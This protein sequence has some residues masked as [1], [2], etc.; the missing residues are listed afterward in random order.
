MSSAACSPLLTLQWEAWIMLTKIA[1]FAERGQELLKEVSRWGAFNI[2]GT[3]SSPRYVWNTE[4]VADHFTSALG[5]RQWIEAQRAIRRAAY[6][7]KPNLR[8]QG[9]NESDDE[10]PR[11]QQGRGNGWT[12]YGNAPRRGSETPKGRKVKDVEGPSTPRVE[13]APR[14]S[15][16]P[17][18]PV[19]P[20]GPVTPRAAIPP[21]IPITPR[22][23]V[24]PRIPVTPRGP[25]TPRAA[26]TPRGQVP[27]HS[28]MSPR[29]TIPSQQSTPRKTTKPIEDYFVGERHLADVMSGLN[30]TPSPLRYKSRTDVAPLPISFGAPSFLD[31]AAPAQQSPLLNLF[32]NS[33]AL[34]QGPV[35]PVSL[36]SALIPRA[37][38]PD[39]GTTVRQGSLDS[40]ARDLPR[41]FIL[42]SEKEEAGNSMP[43]PRSVPRRAGLS[44][45][46]RRGPPTQL[47]NWSFAPLGNVTAEGQ[48]SQRVLPRG[49]RF[50]SW[51]DEM[52]NVDDDGDL[53]ME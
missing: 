26:V 24:S 5:V 38:S 48:A 10:R 31:D 7:G 18:V 34:R 46:P 39:S 21:R 17:R 13:V 28:P 49:S 50:A 25:V 3:A 53:D 11:S 45:A 30:L 6:Q 27:P 42:K 33:S 1:K 40:A 23:P 29:T 15:G 14:G 37:E 9:S 8:G 22:A 35:R 41:S 47:Q 19:T 4:I 44:I 16:T 36:D 43:P 20:R 12:P 2:H 32:P 51:S 52:S